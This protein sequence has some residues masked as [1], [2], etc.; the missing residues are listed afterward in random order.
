MSPTGHSALADVCDHRGVE[1]GTPSD[2]VV[3]QRI[4]NRIIEYLDLAASY[5]AQVAYQAAVPFVTVPYEVINQWDDCVPTDP[6]DVARNVGV[7]SPDEVRA[8]CDFQAVLDGVA[9]AVPNDYPR[10]A[11]VQALP[12][13]D[14]LRH[15]ASS[16]RDVF[17][18]RGRLSEDH[19]VID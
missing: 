2:R 4:R 12:E 13:W 15:A 5:E 14:Q 19:E 6:R 10:L 9:D 1:G 16:A 11:D 17:A 7:F 3:E 18:V 8:M